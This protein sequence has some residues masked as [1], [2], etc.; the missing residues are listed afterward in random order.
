[1]SGA[2]GGGDAAF[3]HVVFLPGTAEDGYRWLRI[4]NGGIAA[5]GEGVPESSDGATIAVA[6]AEDV[7]LHWASLPDR[8]LAQSTAAARVLVAEASATALD[9]LHVA[10]GREPMMEDRPIGVV[11]SARMQNW[12][13]DLARYGVD[14]DAVIPAPMLLPRPDE[15]FL[16][17]DLGSEGVVRG[18]TTG[19]AHDSQLTPLITGGVAPVMMSREDIEEAIVAAVGA[20]ALDLRQGIFAKRRRAT[21]DWPLLRRM[22]WLAVGI[23]TV[24]LL[25]SLVQIMQYGFAADAIERRIDLLARQ[26]LARGETV[27]DAARQLDARLVRLRGPGRGFSATAAA[28][29]G[30]IRNVTG[31]EVRAL[32]FDAKGEAQVTIA[33]QTEG[34]V[35]D[36]IREI[37]AQGFAATTGTFEQANN[38]LTGRITVAPK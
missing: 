30:A 34:Q 14:P 1:M 3:A 10:V 21:I 27:N 19:F 36:V 2:R 22:G 17:A 4:A 16:L 18:P 23:L 29:Y 8:S 15:G 26:G 13:V 11:S 25:I 20:P 12:L 6:P 24:T 31:T 38:R 5:R 28:I 9:H 7:T 33:A 37:G 32:S 35:Y